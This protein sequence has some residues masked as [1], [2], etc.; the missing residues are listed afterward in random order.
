[1]R[2]LR[3]KIAVLSG[4]AV[5]LVAGAAVYG[6]VSTGTSTNPK[7]MAKVASVSLAMAP[8]PAPVRAPVRAH[9]AK[10]AKLERG[11]CIVHVHRVVHVE[12]VIHIRA[13]QPAALPVARQALN[14]GGSSGSGDT[15]QAGVQSAGARVQ[16]TVAA[17]NEP[18]EADHEDADSAGEEA[19]EAAAHAA[20]GDN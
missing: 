6:V 9:C 2:T 3:P 20:E 18:A 14:H 12:H 13:A 11:V 15:S 5:G 19:K 8:V 17:P 10:G 1:M 7:P 4:A 16:S